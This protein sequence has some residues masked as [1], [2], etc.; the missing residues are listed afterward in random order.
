M[1]AAEGFLKAC[2]FSGI[3][4][5]LASAAVGSVPGAS[6]FFASYESAKSVLP[7]NLGA[8]KSMIA[9]S[10]GETIACLIRVPTENVK[11]K[12]Q[13]GLYKTTSET[14]TA[15]RSAPGG[16]TNFYT[17]YWTTVLREVPFS[18]IQFPIWEG[19]KSYIATYQGY[20]ATSFQAAVCGTIS[21]SF[22]AAVTTPLDVIK[23]R[24]MLGTDANGKA[25][26]GLVNTFNRILSEEGWRAFFSGIAPRVFWI[27]LGGFVFL[28]TY[29][30]VIKTM[31]KR[32][33]EDKETF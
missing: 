5:G 31:S 6:L 33:E 17:G 16:W 9:A 18:F 3:Y 22:A 23:T 15:I 30:K 21:G 4:N 8:A 12:M 14:L 24:L 28:G 25:Y 13:A 19:M 7:D 1:Q 32:D 2:G 11:Q 10:F 26:N 20:E 29:D 27:G